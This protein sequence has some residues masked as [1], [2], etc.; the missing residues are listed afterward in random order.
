MASAMTDREIETEGTYIGTNLANELKATPGH[1][2]TH[3]TDEAYLLNNPEGSSLS[4]LQRRLSDARE[5]YT[6]D[7]RQVALAYWYAVDA[8]YDRMTGEEDTRPI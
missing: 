4:L 2:R 7:E 5:R 1:N 6:W 8:Y 3:S